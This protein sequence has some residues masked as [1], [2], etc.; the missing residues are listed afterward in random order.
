MSEEELAAKLECE[1]LSAQECRAKIAECKAN[2][3]FMD[4]LES[5][6]DPAGPLTRQMWT[7][8]HK[9]GYAENDTH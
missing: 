1:N 8:L 4:R 9:K 3:K 6:T 5:F 7:H 2:S